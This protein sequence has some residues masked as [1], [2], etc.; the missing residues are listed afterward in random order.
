M[1]LNDSMLSVKVKFLFKKKWVFRENVV[2]L[3][4][5]KGRQKFR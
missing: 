4:C 1:C 3:Q 2:Y 5:E